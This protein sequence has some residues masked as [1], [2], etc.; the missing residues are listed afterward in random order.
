MVRSKSVLI[1]GEC[2]LESLAVMGHHVWKS[3][4]VLRKGEGKNVVKCEQLENVGE[5]MQEFFISPLHP[6][7][8]FEIISK[9]F[10]M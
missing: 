4:Y 5:G 2:T 8:M 9:L 1:L 3:L 7:C 6:F 10:K